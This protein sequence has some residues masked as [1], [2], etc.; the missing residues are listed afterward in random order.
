MTKISM[1]KHEEKVHKDYGGDIISRLYDQ[2]DYEEKND[3][4]DERTLR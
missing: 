4:D 3:E 2:D 1:M